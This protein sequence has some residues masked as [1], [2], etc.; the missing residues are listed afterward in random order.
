M[1]TLAEFRTVMDLIVAGWLKPVQDRSYP[2]K[3]ASSAQERL[4]QGEQLGKI[5]LAIG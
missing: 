2:L 5:T 4:K 3:D 1:S